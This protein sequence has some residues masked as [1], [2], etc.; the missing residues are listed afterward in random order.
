MH[1]T[2]RRLS[3]KFSWLYA[4][5]CL[6]LNTSI[7]WVQIRTDFGQ[8]LLQKKIVAP[9]ATESELIIDY[10]VSNIFND[11]IEFGLSIDPNTSSLA[12]R[13]SAQLEGVINRVG[14]N[15]QG[16]LPLGKR[17]GIKLQYAPQFENYI[18]ETGATQRIRCVN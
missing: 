13:E 9:A 12:G 18:G 15:I 4:L 7:G 2:I 16:T 14:V 1:R 8:Q 10:Q 17:F 11:H 6:F 5:I 3:F